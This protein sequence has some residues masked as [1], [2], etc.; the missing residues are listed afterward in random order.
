MNQNTSGENL[1]RPDAA[2]TAGLVTVD[3]PI[4]ERATQRALARRQAVYADEV[5]RLL[6]AGL[7]VM[8]QCGTAKS[9]PV[10][11]IVAAA[12][13]SRDAF[14]RHFASKEDLVAAIVEAGA[15]RLR[16]YLR[17]QM[18][19]EDAPAAQLRRWI[20]G[21]MAQATDPDVAHSTRAVLWNGG[22]SGDQAR[23]DVVA[24]PGPLAE[25]IVAPIAA[26]GS[27]DPARDAT[28]VTHATMGLMRDFLWRCVTPTPE[29]IS[30]LVGFCTA[31]VLSDRPV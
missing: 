2:G 24:S 27:T 1:A 14:Y 23:S 20:E 13:L 31:A 12:R 28:V 10:S 6:D 4:V 19:K 7:E 22:R 11:D 30:H 8:R 5:R 3:D 17:H 15:Q 26:L 9:P 18:G 29:D 21:I 25:L 16:G